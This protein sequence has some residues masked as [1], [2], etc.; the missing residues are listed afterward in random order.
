MVEKHWS[1]AVS[2][3][4]SHLLSWPCPTSG[5]WTSSWTKVAEQ[6]FWPS[7]TCA[8]ALIF[9]SSV[10]DHRLLRH[11][12]TQITPASFRTKLCLS[13]VRLQ[14]FDLSWYCWENQTEV[15]A[16]GQQ[17]NG[18]N[19]LEWQR[20]KK[21]HNLKSEGILGHLAGIPHERTLGGDRVLK[22]VSTHH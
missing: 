14:I 13:K 10:K 12:R 6:W 17:W 22:V 4:C 2:S 15:S 8:P 21:F 18:I 16:G 9:K 20:C 3:T 11:I 5:L 1:T 19:G 7:Y